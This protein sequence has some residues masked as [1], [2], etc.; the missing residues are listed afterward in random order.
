LAHIHLNKF[1]TKSI[2][3]IL[4]KIEGREPA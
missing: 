4:Y 3:H 2:F 1:P